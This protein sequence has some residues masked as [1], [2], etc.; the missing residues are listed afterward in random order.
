MNQHARRFGQAWVALSLTLALHVLDEALTHFLDLYNPLVTRVRQ[1][2]PFLPL[3]VF[4]FHVWLAGLILGV[5]LLLA[6]SVF[7]F[8]GSPVMRPLAFVLGGL[9]IL[10]ACGH[11][12]GSLYY[13]RWLPGVFS[14][15]ILLAA[16]IYLIYR[17][18]SF[19]P[20]P[21]S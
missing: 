12:G 5:I 11:L 13:G 20:S 9:M 4:T 15:P 7:V 6:L 2:Y 8:R 10:N 16:S 14:S 1:A 19:T 21:S 3:P 17:S 18:C